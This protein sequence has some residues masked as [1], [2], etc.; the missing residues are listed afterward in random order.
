M[1]LLARFGRLAARFGPKPATKQ[2]GRRQMRLG[3]AVR[4]AHLPRCGS[5]QPA[6]HPVDVELVDRA[7]VGLAEGPAVD[8]VEGGVDE[9]LE[10]R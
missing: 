7:G 8:L 5:G 9:Q 1:T 4:E 3:A 6:P 2:R 10:L